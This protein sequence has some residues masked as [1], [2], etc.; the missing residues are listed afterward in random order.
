MP[1]SRQ[2]RGA[3]PSDAQLF[4]PSKLPALRTAAFELSWL[5]SRGYSATSAL[6]L[7]GDRHHLQKRRRLALSRAACSD[8]A[9]HIR[10]AKCLQLE[11]IQGEELHID[12][13]NLLINIEAALGGGLILRCRDGCFR[14][15]AG[16][17]GSYRSVE[18]TRQAILFIGK[19]LETFGPHSVDWLLDKPVSNSG[20]LA[21]FIREI[22]TEHSWPWSVELVFNPDTAISESPKIAVSSDSS[23]LDRVGRWANLSAYVIEAFLPQAWI[24]DLRTEPPL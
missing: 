12:G 4:A 1:D 9:L 18:E 24:I 16:V 5:L 23:V 20:R 17:H 13:F 3:H 6:K 7:V 19:T 22:A 8:Q 2:H 15:I 11:N 14:D 10:A 21:G